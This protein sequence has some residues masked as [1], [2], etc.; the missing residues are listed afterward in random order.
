MPEISAEE[1][2][3]LREAASFATQVVPIEKVVTRAANAAAEEAVYR[4]A[5][6]GWGKANKEEFDIECPSGQLC[7][8]KPLGIEDAMSLGLLD[9]L[10]LFTSTLMA[11][12]MANEEDKEKAEDDHNQTILKGLRDP[13]K[14]A[15]FFGT[16][17]RV[18][19]H[20]VVQPKVVLVDDGSL[21]EDEVF[22]NDIPFEDKMHI[23]RRV[24]R[25]SQ[26]GT[27]NTFREGSEGSVDAVPDS[28]PV[29]GASE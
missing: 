26:S 25:G 24:F 22:A 6:T 5:K 14:R 11:P 23:F 10:D 28:D 1:L 29:S 21:A 17:N 13:E 20:C 8:A 18:V 16:V 2:A 7:R 15:S 9:S 27:M 12:V 19:Q 3:Q 4:Y